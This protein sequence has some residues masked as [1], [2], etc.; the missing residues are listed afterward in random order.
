MAQCVNRVILIGRLGRDPEMRYTNDGEAVTTFSLATDRPVRPGA[1]PVTDWHRV[2]CWS[3]LA[4]TAGQYLS[5]GRL[6]CVIGRLDYRSWEGRDGQRRT[7]AEV[8]A[9]ELTLLDRR[10]DAAPSDPTD[11]AGEATAA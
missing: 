3:K 2:V 5:K 4:E 7:T 9:A 10:P 8:I 6:V 11:E 1:E